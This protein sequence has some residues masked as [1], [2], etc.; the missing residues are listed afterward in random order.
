MYPPTHTTNVSSISPYQRHQQPVKQSSDVG[1]LT[2]DMNSLKMHSPSRPQPLSSQ[3]QFMSSP[4]T[5]ATYRPSHSR[6]LPSLTPSYY[7]TA[8]TLKTVDSSSAKY[9]YDTSSDSTNVCVVLILS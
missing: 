8:Q 5:T 4:Y 6:T 2:A 9:N 7:Q 1:K 3:H